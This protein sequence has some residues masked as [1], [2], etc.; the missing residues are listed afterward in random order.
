MARTCSVE[1]LVLH[2]YDVGEADRFLLLFT[3]E[4]GRLAARARGVRRLG[5]R[6]GGHLLAHQHLSLTL[7]ESSAGWTVTSAQRLNHSAALPIEQFAMA[8][9][10][11]EL[12]LALLHDEEALP[13][14]FDLTLHFLQSCREGQGDPVLAFSLELLRLLGLLP[15]VTE[16]EFPGHLAPQAIRTIEEALRS[17]G[18]LAS[19]PP[20]LLRSL[21][22]LCRERIEEHANRTSRCLSVTRQLKEWAVPAR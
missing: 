15:A 10:G 9:E 1:A 20:A 2:A 11:C 22:I 13:A 4:R 21:S 6:M 3:R 12:L 7:A 16:K 5:S 18:S 8:E 14:I 17:S 19:L